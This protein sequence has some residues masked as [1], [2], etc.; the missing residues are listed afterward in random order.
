MLNAGCTGNKTV[1]PRQARKLLHFETLMCK[2]VKDLSTHLQERLLCHCICN[3]CVS[4]VAGEDPAYTILSS[5]DFPFPEFPFFILH[6]Q[7]GHSACSLS[8]CPQPF[9]Y[10]C[11]LP[12]GPVTTSASEYLVKTQPPSLWALCHW[13][14]SQAL[15][16]RAFCQNYMEG[17]SC[18]LISLHAYISRSYLSSVQR[19]HNLCVYLHMSQFSSPY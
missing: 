7:A 11:Q 10:L 18:L 2:V 8:T 3:S 16:D 9:S 15:S 13:D 14:H 19:T 1:V 6:L 12:A 17:K 4:G 5:L